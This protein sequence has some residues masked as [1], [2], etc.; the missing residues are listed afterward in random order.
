MVQHDGEAAWLHQALGFLVTRHGKRGAA[1]LLGVTRP[2]LEDWSA[3]STPT[4]RMRE[5]VETA[6]REM[7]ELPESFQ[8]DRMEAIAETVEDLREEVGSFAGRLEHLE[9]QQTAV[10]PVAALVERPAPASPLRRWIRG[11]FG[12]SGT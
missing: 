12:G 5:A 9:R 1:R 10:I 3:R 8:A 6:V 4:P 7:E 11:V 2:T